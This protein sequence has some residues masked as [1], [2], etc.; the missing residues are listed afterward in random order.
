MLQPAFLSAHDCSNDPNPAGSC[1]LLT[2]K[3]KVF[4][5]T[6]PCY[7]PSQTQSAG[8]V[9]MDSGQNSPLII[10][11]QFYTAELPTQA[12]QELFTPLRI[13]AMPPF[14]ITSNLTFPCLLHFH[15]SLPTA[16][17]YFLLIFKITMDFSMT[18]HL[19]YLLLL[20]FGVF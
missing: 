16:Q 7:S 8:H 18:E 20:A 9:P 14:Q 6:E 2:A 11:D 15:K 5:A 12:S 10:A 3:I 17:V 4:L 1:F 13:F 19:M